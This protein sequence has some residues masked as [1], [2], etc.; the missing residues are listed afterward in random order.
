MRKSLLKFYLEAGASKI[1][2]QIGWLPGMWPTWIQ[3]LVSC[4]VLL[5]HQVPEHKARNKSYAQPDVPPKWKQTKILV[6]ENARIWI[7]TALVNHT[8]GAGFKF[9]LSYYSSS[10]VMLNV[11]Y[12]QIHLNHP[13]IKAF[14][15]TQ[16]YYAMI[17]HDN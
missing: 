8:R 17:F 2:Q 14:S 12:D 7:F 15:F 6:E 3:L 5:N 9:S 4:M 1:V 10:T 11:F 16:W 13:L